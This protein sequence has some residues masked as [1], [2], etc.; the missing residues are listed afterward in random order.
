[1]QVFGIY[2]LLFIYSV[3]SKLNHNYQDQSY[4]HPSKVFDSI[5]ENSINSSENQNSILKQKR[6]IQINI[7]NEEN[8]ENDNDVKKENFDDVEMIDPDDPHPLNN[9]DHNDSGI[10]KVYDEA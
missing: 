3:Q 1:M 5:I 10:Y 4:L 8:K 7:V 2:F 9:E 6:N